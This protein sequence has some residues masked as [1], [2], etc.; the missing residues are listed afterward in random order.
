[1]LVVVLLGKLSGVSELV[2]PQNMAAQWLLMQM[3]GFVKISWKVPEAIH[4]WKSRV[5]VK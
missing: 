3:Q 2:Y 1:M 4:Y 5:E